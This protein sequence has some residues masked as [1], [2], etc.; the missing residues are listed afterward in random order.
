MKKQTRIIICILLAFIV[1]G[2]IG[3]WVFVSG[4]PADETY[5][6]SWEENGNK[7]YFNEPD[8]DAV[9]A[10][11]LAL[12]DGEK[13]ELTLEE[14]NQYYGRDMSECYIPENLVKNNL[15]EKFDFYYDGD[16]VT[17]DRAV[18]WYSI[19]GGTGPDYPYME[20]EFQKGKI[21]LSDMIYADSDIKESIIN[22]KKVTF[23]AEFPEGS[24]N[25]TA[26]FLS[27]EIGYRVQGISISQEEFMKVI[28]S[29]LD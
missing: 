1:L 11:K 5:S 4:N 6:A 22:G 28:Y 29:L 9:A 8:H 23:T 10:A 17:S 24:T 13:K 20:I 25:Y 27:N 16:I 3:I 18:L 2:G 7:V 14:V 26:E 12:P 19:E 21:P 15:K